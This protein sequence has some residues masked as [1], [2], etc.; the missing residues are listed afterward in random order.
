MQAWE[1]EKVFGELD[2]R[3]DGNGRITSL[4]PEEKILVSGNFSR[5]NK[6][7][8]DKNYSAGETAS[9]RSAIARSGNIE[10]VPDDPE[11]ISLLEPYSK[12]IIEFYKQIVGKAE[13][14]LPKPVLGQIIADAMV[15]KSRQIGQNVSISFINTGGV[16]SDILRGDISIGKIY[17]VQPFG[18][19][20]FLLDMTGAQVKEALEQG[21]LKGYPYVSGIRYTVETKRAPG[22]RITSLEIREGGGSYRPIDPSAVYRVAI[23]KFLANGGD[24]FTVFK[25]WDGY[26][27]ETG[28]LDADILIDYLKY[29]KSWDSREPSRVTIK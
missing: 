4:I 11:A 28:Y 26:R 10:I 29:K 16:R 6:V 24:N 21:V 7:N 2:V 19:I 13:E 15:W 8:P 20:M 25:T 18:D 23:Q 22:S 12:G 5:D 1:W 3:F 27:Y 9:I 17:E 14:D